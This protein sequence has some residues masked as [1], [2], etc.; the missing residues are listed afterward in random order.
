MLPCFALQHPGWCRRGGQGAGGHLVTQGLGQHSGT[1]NQTWLS[2]RSLNPS[3]NP[4]LWIWERTGSPSLP[5]CLASVGWHPIAL[6]S[7]L[8]PAFQAKDP[9]VFRNVNSLLHEQKYVLWVFGKEQAPRWECAGYT[10]R[11]GVVLL[12]VRLLRWDRAGEAASQASAALP[13][14]PSQCLQNCNF[15]CNDGLRLSQF[16]EFCHVCLIKENRL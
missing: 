2:L 6:A 1:A 12:V 13:A 14:E 9:L 11:R 8:C 10:S 15:H 16:T 4:R 5:G 3:V 7:M